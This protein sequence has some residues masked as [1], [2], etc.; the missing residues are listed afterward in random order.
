MSKISQKNL[1]KLLILICLFIILLLIYGVIRIYA[2]FHSELNSEVQLKNGIWNIIVNEV[3]ITKGKDIKFD[4]KDI[5][6]EENSHVKPGKIAP[7]LTGNFKI[8]IDPQ[9]TNVSVRYDVS[10][11]EQELTNSNLVI[12][13]ITETQ[14]GNKLVRVAKNTYA[15]IISLEEIK[16]ENK[17]EITVEIEWLDNEDDSNKDVDVGAHAD[18]VYKIPIAIHVSQYLGEELK[19]YTEN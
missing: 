18:A 19:A 13:S 7:G 3:D 10:L 4:I 6:I 15:G 12:K 5:S 8:S 9:N 14:R 17:N 1:S 11:D 16:K 2:L